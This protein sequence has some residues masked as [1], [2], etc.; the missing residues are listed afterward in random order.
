ME[1]EPSAAVMARSSRTGAREDFHGFLTADHL[2]RR[3]LCYL[4]RIARS[5]VPVL[6][7]G[8]TGTGKE[9]LARATHTESRRGGEFVSVNCACLSPELAPSEM[10]G[11]AKGSF[12]D[13]Y[14]DRKGLLEVANNGTVFLDEIGEMPL[15]AQ[16]ALL[17]VLRD[18][19]LRAVGSNYIG[20]I[21][22]RVVAATNSNLER[23]VEEGRFR[24][25]LYYRIRGA[26]VQIP[27]LRERPA[28]IEVLVNCFVDTQELTER[29]REALTRFE[30]PGNVQELK[31]AIQHMVALAAGG[32]L[33]ISHLPE[34]VVKERIPERAVQE[35]PS[36]QPREPMPDY[37][38]RVEKDELIRTLAK[39]GGNARAASDD[40][41]YPTSTM[42]DKLRRHR[43]RR[44]RAG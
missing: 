22:I 23:L 42:S 33:D 10:L 34:S 14:S 31:T 21:D 44:S 38:E 43:L 5:K 32:T 15:G 4:R 27:P 8:E 37:L 17:R 16:V 7:L 1:S 40:L 6:L 13:A 12:T 9:L 41:R 29:A 35:G 11:H 2:I 19:E 26:V 24:K 20:T 30:W 28:D 18:G 25:D 3:A 39:H 36:R